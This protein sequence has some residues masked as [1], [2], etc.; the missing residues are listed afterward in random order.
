MTNLTTIITQ[1]ME[2]RNYSQK[3]IKAYIRVISENS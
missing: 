1:E 2:L 3:T